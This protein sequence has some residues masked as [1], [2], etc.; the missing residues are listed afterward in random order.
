MDPHQID[1][2]ARAPADPLDRPVVPVQAADADRPPVRLPLQ[3]VADRDAAG[4][5]RAGHD[6]SMPGHGERAV[7]RHAEQLPDRGAGVAAMQA[8]WSASLSS[9]NPWPVTAE[10][11]TIAAPSRNVP[12]TQ[13]AHILLDQV[14][15]GRLGQVA[16]G[17]HDHARPQAR[18]AGESPDVRESGA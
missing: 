10:V 1:R 17:Q 13:A 3:L 14:E 12:R 7:D 5:D 15:P 8:A 18:G 11:R 16:F 9:A 4:G 6:R 2:G